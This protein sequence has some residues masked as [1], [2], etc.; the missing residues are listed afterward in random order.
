[1]TC[2]HSPNGFISKAWGP[3]LWFLLHL[4]SFHSKID[5][6]HKW[7]ILLGDVLPCGSCRMNFKSNLEQSGYKQ[8][9]F[10]SRNSVSMFLWKF[11]NEV[12]KCLRKKS[13]TPTF[14]HVR[15]YYGNKN[16]LYEK[17]HV[18]ITSPI[19]IPAQLR[20]PYIKS[21]VTSHKTPPIMR[22]WWFIIIICSLNFPLDQ[23]RSQS[24]QE[25]LILSIDVL[26][27]CFSYTKMLLR[28]C[29]SQT[30]IY[31][32]S[33]CNTRDD[34]VRFVFNMLQ[35]YCDKTNGTYESVDNIIRRYEFL[36]A[37]ECTKSTNKIEGTCQKGKRDYICRIIPMENNDNED[38][39]TALSLHDHCFLLQCAK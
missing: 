6:F 36:R 25:W 22:L 32:F 34:Y 29:V 14:G 16:I 39:T 19:D 38:D 3:V 28:Y 8:S 35:I 5:I 4:F 23:T 37:T 30:N 13:D 24:Y 20:L 2:I 33:T 21:N 17:I 26:P 12:N 27:E 18:H 1:M 31:Y 9:I 15:S 11:H 7:F 10:T